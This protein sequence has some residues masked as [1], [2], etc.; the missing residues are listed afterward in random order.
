MWINGNKNI[1][2]YTGK[3]NILFYFLAIV[4]IHG[5]L[6]IYLYS[7]SHGQGYDDLMLI[8]DFKFK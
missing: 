7:V 2:K 6:I 4:V 5:N 1:Y 8:I 3:L